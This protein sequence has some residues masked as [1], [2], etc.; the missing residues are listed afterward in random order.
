MDILRSTLLIILLICIKTLYPSSTCFQYSNLAMA[1]LGFIIEEVSGQSY[2]D[3]IQALILDPLN[4]SD[5]RPDMPRKYLSEY[6][7]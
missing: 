7:C 3:Y 5:T 4:L 1:L 6:P 2:D